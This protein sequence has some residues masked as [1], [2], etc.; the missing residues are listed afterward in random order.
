MTDDPD[1]LNLR[2]DDPMVKWRR[3][4]NA[5]EEERARCRRELR[6]QEQH[7]RE[8]TSVAE[9]RAEMRQEIANLR[10]ELS[11]QRELLLTASGQAMGDISNKFFDRIDKIERELLGAIECR[12]GEAQGRLDGALA[13]LGERTRPKDFRFS[14]EQRD[15]EKGV[16]DLPNP[17]TPLVRK[18]TVN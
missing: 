13:N 4:A 15:D 12:F 2:P 18:V 5:A 10:V 11:A 17:L 3:E 8:Q 9:L 6:E 14:N 1:P 7:E 16:V